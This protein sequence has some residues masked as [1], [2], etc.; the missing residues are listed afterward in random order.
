VDQ[1]KHPVDACCEILRTRGWVFT[2][3]SVNDSAC[4]EYWRIDCAA[5]NKCL[6]I[7]A[8][9]RSEAWNLAVQEILRSNE[10]K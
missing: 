10:D 9:A 6:A 1:T 5:G 3:A 7:L 8:P 2:E 4:P